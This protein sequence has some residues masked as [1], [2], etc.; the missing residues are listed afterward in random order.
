MHHTLVPSDRVEHVCVFGRDG[1]KLGSIER[2]MLD[3]V[4]GTVAYA[5]IKTGGVLSSHHHYPIRWTA[6]HF[7]PNRQAFEAEVTLEDLRTGPS[8]FDGDEF[9]WGDRSRSYTHPNYWAV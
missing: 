4:S 7:D 6:L 3:K 5:I 2:L 1:A 8:E 9:D